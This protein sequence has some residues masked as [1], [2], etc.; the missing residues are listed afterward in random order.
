MVPATGVAPP[1]NRLPAPLGHTMAEGYDRF[2][3]GEG[4][5]PQQGMKFR[6][7]PT[8]SLMPM[9]VRPWG[10]MLR[11]QSHSTSLRSRSVLVIDQLAVSHQR[12][13]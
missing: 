2:R 9:S 13:G 8:H 7:K 3:A 12:G 1:A 5:S 6:L 10:R 11:S 4:E